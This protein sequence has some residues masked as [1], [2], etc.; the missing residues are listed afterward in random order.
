MPLTV[1]LTNISFQGNH[2]K[3]TLICCSN[4]TDFNQILFW[5]YLL[6]SP[7]GFMLFKRDSNVYNSQTYSL[8]AIKSKC[9]RI[10]RYAYNSHETMLQTI[11]PKKV[12][13]ETII[14]I[15]SSFM[16]M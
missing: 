1:F 11:P 15:S 13:L 14:H 6:V 3:N 2:T 7:I 5:E 9:L 10:L 4:S 16:L 12:V 8:A